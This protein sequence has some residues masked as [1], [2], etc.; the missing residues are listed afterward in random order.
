MATRPTRLRCGAAG[1]EDLACE[2][3]DTKP[4]PNEG[5]RQRHANQ[6]HDLPTE[7]VLTEQQMQFEC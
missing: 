3:I 2:Q 4:V 6:A 5:A 7:L 1:L